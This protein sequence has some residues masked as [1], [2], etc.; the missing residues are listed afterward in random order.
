M[1]IR[2]DSIEVSEEA[3]R[4]EAQYHPAASFDVAC[5]QA[6]QALVVRQLLL[7]EAARRGIEADPT[8]CEQAIGE[9]MDVAVEVPD[10]EASACEVFYEQRP[11]GFRGP[12]L[13]A[14]SHILFAAEV[15]DQVARAEAKRRAA[16][17]LREIEAK[18]ERFARIAR[19]VSGC[20]S[21]ASGGSL[22][23][24][25]RGESMPEFEAAI[26][27]LQPEQLSPQP[28]ETKAGFHVIRLDDRVPG[29]RLPFSAVQDRILIYLRDRAWRQAVQTFVASLAE[30]AKIEG[31]ELSAD[32]VPAAAR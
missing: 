8:D 23:Q 14:P 17:V 12:E 20:P 11:D 13:F 27:A 29:E 10:V 31:F 1:S 7:N 16:T 15:G 3:I 22:G 28:V 21:G 4:R 26:E 18:P 32:L 9:L 24:I 5:N 19:S 6:S 2:V 30:N 25:T